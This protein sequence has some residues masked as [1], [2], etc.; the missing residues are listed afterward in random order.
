MNNNPI[1]YKLQNIKNT[2]TNKLNENGGLKIYLIIVIPILVF[3][4]FLFFKY[5]FN[6]RNTSKIKSL[7]YA[8]KLQLKNLPSCTDIDQI[9]RYKL[10]DYYISSSYMTPCIGNLHYD[11]VSL[12]MIKTVILSGARY[13]QIPICTESVN[14]QSKPVVA[15]AIYGKQAITSLNTLDVVDVLNTIKSYC[16]VRDISSP[17]YDDDQDDNINYPLIVHFFLNTTNTFTLNMLANS[18]KNTIGNIIVKASDYQKFPIFLEQVCKLLNK[19]ILIATPEYKN[20]KLEDVIIPTSTLFET[21]YYGDIGRFSSGIATP[22]TTSSNNIRSSIPITTSSE[23]SGYATHSYLNRLSEKQQ[24]D[25]IAVFNEK[26]SSLQY[27][28]DNLD[29]V[30]NSVLS[31]SDLLNN[32]VCFNKIGMSVIKPHN[33]EDVM[34]TNYDPA[35][36]FHYGSQFV[37]MN[38]QND[39]DNMK[40]YLKVFKISSFRLKPAS[41]RFSETE[42]PTM[43]MVTA[44]SSIEAINHNIL[45]TFMNS[46]NNKLITIESYALPNTFLTQI[47]QTLVFRTPSDLDQTKGTTSNETSATY[48]LLTDALQESSSKLTPKIGLN[49]CFKVIK[50]SLSGSDV[51]IYL[52]SVGKPG[53]FITINNT[54]FSLQEL[55]EKT[56]VLKTQSFYPTIPKKSDRETTKQMVSFRLVDDKNPQFLGFFNKNV[57]VYQNSDN[58]EAMTNMSFYVA[59]ISFQMNV[60][61]TTIN[62][63]SIMTSGSVVGVLQNNITAST[64]YIVTPATNNS[65][66]KITKDAFT[67][68]NKN[69]G[70]YLNYDE[71]TKL[72]YDN[73]ITPN[74]KSIFTLKDSKGFYNIVNNV[75]NNL[76]IVNGIQ[77]IF[78]D[79][80]TSNNVS[81]LFKMNISYKL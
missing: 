77:L 53:Y 79:P 35:E 7:S 74:S 52:E 76:E 17:S 55:G 69:T 20:T 18:I 4:L 32:L 70:T 42:G 25:N 8:S 66:F 12:D 40:N 27:V 16:F 73:I 22:I 34:V 45:P 31:D 6:Q 19:V 56:A 65:N 9:Y 72:L 24:T 46:F 23:N 49:Q 48:P 58:D 10:C 57:K 37:A 62:G 30:G 13:I 43:N 2:V 29:T 68:K 67:L 64:S 60:T 47:D 63:G 26:Y 61:F 38:F 44:Y 28:V 5:T 71:S 50:S 78:K 39:D 1:A 54:S 11:Y 21:F 33:P 3:L 51:S 81:N 80:T 59:E 75:G 14:F 36:A 41:L 15:T